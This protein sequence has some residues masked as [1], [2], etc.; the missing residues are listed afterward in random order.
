MT[1]FPVGSLESLKA[2]KDRKGGVFIIYAELWQ[3]AKRA[4]NGEKLCELKQQMS[5]YRRK[6]QKEMRRGRRNDSHR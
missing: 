3:T 2:I 4:R 6:I 5:D 1:K